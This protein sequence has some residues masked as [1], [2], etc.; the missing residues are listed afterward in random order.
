MPGKKLGRLPTLS[1][2]KVTLQAPYV[3]INEGKRPSFDLEKPAILKILRGTGL[4]TSKVDSIREILQ[5]AVDST[6]I[7]IWEQHKEKII[8]LTPNSEELHRLYDEKPIVVDFLPSS[9]STFTLTVKDLGMGISRAD[10]ERMLRIGG[11][12]K[13]SSRSRLIRDMPSW[14]KPSGN[15]GIGLQSVSLLAD[16]FIIRTKSRASNEAFGITFNLGSA[17]SVIIESIAPES[18]DYGATFAVD[19][20]IEEFPE[21]ISIPFGSERS[22]LIKEI[23][24][25]DFTEPGSDLKIYEQVKIFEAIHRFNHHSPIK[26]LSNKNSTPEDRKEIYFAREQNIILSNI[27][28]Q[29]SDNC[30]IRTFFRGQEFSGLSSTLPLVSCEV[31][32]YGHEALDFLTYNREKILP[33][34]KLNAANDL[35]DALLCFIDEKF[36]TLENHQRECAAAFYLLNAEKGSN[37]K[38]YD[39]LMNYKINIESQGDIPL[40]AVIDRIKN[41]EITDFEARRKQYSTTNTTA[42][43]LSTLAVLKSNA[44]STN[45]KLIKIAATKSG[46][47]WQEQFIPGEYNSRCHWSDK[48]ICPTDN[49]I[50]KDIIGGER[51][52]FDIGKRMLFPAWDCYRDLAVS[53]KPNWART[54]YHLSYNNE[55]LV[56]PYSFSHE[57]PAVPDKSENLIT[58]VFENRAKKDITLENIKKLYEKLIKEIDSM[59]EL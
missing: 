43:H 56:L 15:F 7:A 46:L 12:T 48:D 51:D 57:G 14:F 38:Y 33:H 27:N 35:T 21:T 2:P 18:I 41:K 31:D 22:I 5:N 20:A 25:Y 42:D 53:V 10:I 36:S 23:N 17:S 47:F 4:Y 11:S 52:L 26:I 3:I 55:T 28:F 58:W 9:R 16:K 40:S 32:F 39:E 44:P 59:T 13:N 50:L 45:L 49:K 24:N 19:I 6:I 34:M 8:K 30:N 37:L 29:Y 1:P 54:K